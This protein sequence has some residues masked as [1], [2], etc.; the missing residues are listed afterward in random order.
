MDDISLRRMEEADLR[1]VL[2]IQAELF[3]DDLQEDI[4]ILRRRCELFPDGCWVVTD[5]D[6]VVGYLVSNPWTLRCP[7]MLGTYLPDLPDAPEGIY[8]HDVGVASSMKGRGVGKHVVR[9]FLEFARE[10]SFPAISLVAVMDS[11]GFWEK[12]GFQLVALA[13]AS[14]Q[15]L[16]DHYGPAACYMTMGLLEDDHA[17]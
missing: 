8:L 4:S 3:T 12:Q 2:A 14:R 15:S 13:E 9:A 1:A 5:Q 16:A 17:S 7:P 6:R 11:R 10:R